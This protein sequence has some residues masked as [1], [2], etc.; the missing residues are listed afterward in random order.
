MILRGNCYQ[1]SLLS[2]LRHSILRFFMETVFSSQLEHL[3]LCLA[4][5]E[6]LR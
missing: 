3:Q 2:E 6:L 5:H 4:T 1:A